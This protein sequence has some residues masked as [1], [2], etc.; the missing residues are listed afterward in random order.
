MRKLSDIIIEEGIEDLG[1]DK[2][3]IIIRV[4]ICKN[5]KLLMVYLFIFK[6]YIFLGGGMK[7]DEDYISVFKREVKEEIGV[8]EVFN[9][10]FYGYIEEKRYGILNRLIVYF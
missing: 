3:R 10:K 9:I 7:K 5:D 1:I 6:D 2:I 8:S 4:I